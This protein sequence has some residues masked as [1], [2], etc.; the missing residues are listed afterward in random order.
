MKKPDEKVIRTSDP[1]WLGKAL[2]HYTERTP[3]KLVDDAGLGLSQKDLRTAVDLLHSLREKKFSTRKL[4]QALAGLGLGGVG[5]GLVLLAIVDPEPTSKLSILLAGG[6]VLIL[7]GGLAVLKAL[8]QT[9]VVRV[10]KGSFT[11]E[12]GKK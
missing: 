5:I 7:A 10:G 1:G 4:L 8:G 9:W 3:F 12:P 2:T 6:V 11:V